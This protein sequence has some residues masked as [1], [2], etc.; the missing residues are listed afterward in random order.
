[1]ADDRLEI[2]VAGRTYATTTINGNTETREYD[3][4]ADAGATHIGIPENE[5]EEL[6]LSKSALLGRKGVVLDTSTVSA[7]LWAQLT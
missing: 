5:L 6:G 1:M 4:P 7:Y 3:F 2:S